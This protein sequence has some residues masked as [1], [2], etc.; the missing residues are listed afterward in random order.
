MPRNLIRE[1]AYRACDGLEVA[2]LWTPA[3]NRLTV[4]VADAR[5]GDSFELSTR[6]ETALDAFHHPFAYATATAT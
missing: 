4:A 1:L 2:L 6:P 5:T 3:D